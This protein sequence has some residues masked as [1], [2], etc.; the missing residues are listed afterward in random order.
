M[1]DSKV[2]NRINNGYVISTNQSPHL[3]THTYNKLNNIYKN[4]KIKF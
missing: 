2:S 1:Q 3:R 4:L